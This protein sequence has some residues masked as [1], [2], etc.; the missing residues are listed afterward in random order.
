M[1][2]GYAEVAQEMLRDRMEEIETHISFIKTLLDQKASLL[3][4]QDKYEAFKIIHFDLSKDFVRTQ[5]AM[6]Y[7]LLYNTIEAVMT[8]L[9]DG[10]YTSLLEG[11][12]SYDSMKS[13]LQ[14]K[15]LKNFR[16]RLKDNDSN[17]FL[18]SEMNSIFNEVVARG[19]IKE[20]LFNGNI[21]KKI[22]EECCNDFGFVI[23]D[24]DLS[25]SKNGSCLAIIK[26]K[27][28]ELAHGSLSFK[29]CGKETTIEE[30]HGYSIAVQEY[31]TAIIDGVDY[32]L[33]NNLFIEI[34]S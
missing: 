7:L 11:S 10:I 17:K 25:I 3:A 13:C 34:A 29:Q 12:I 21:T 19:Y 8:E 30:L 31:L 6:T 14:K 5:T 1:D 24:H 20:K 9:I 4:R 32:Y 23:A 2:A 15:L 16:A 22:I 27:R 26:D 18:G 28:N 33:K